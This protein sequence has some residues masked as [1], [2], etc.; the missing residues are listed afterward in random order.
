LAI[1]AAQKL[2][3]HSLDETRQHALIDE[4]FSGVRSGRV[5]VLEGVAL[6]GVSAEVTT[7]LPLTAE[8]KEIVKRDVLSRIGSQAT[9]T[10]RVD[11]SILG[12]MIIRSGGK[13]LDASLAG[14]LESLKQSLS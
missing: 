2:I 13:V 11:P 3:G 4:F 7:A 8:E 12:G 6:S 10:F 5:T 1:A 14:Q 9:V